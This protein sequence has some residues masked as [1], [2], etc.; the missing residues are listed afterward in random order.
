MRLAGNEGFSGTIVPP[1]SSVLAVIDHHKHKTPVRWRIP[2]MDIRPGAGA[3]TTLVHEYLKATEVTVPRWLAALMAYA[4]SSETL[5]MSREAGDADR[6]AWLDLAAR[7]DLK[8]MGHIRHARLPRIYY[9][10][11]QEALTAA[12]RVDHLAWT[13]L[14][15]TA[16]PEIIA[17]V[18]DLLLRMEGTRWSFCTAHMGDRLYVSIRSN[19][20]KARCSQVLRRAMGQNGSSGGHHSMAAG[21]LE[22]TGLDDE[23]REEARRQFEANLVRRLSSDKVDRDAGS[24]PLGE[25]LVE[26]PEPAP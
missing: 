17:E 4:L 18:A 16:Q 9:A 14:H 23:Q 19:Q 24:E 13:H 12:R 7:A 15:Q 3:T 20:R 5:D 10:R 1:H 8:I 26:S 11:L 25:P 22:L 21:F 6:Q 2:Y